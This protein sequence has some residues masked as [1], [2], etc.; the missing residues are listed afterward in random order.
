MEA[1]AQVPIILVINQGLPY[2]SNA[3][4]FVNSRADNSTNV[5]DDKLGLAW[6]IARTQIRLFP[7]APLSSARYWSHSLSWKSSTR[8]QAN[9]RNSPK[10]LKSKRKKESLDCATKSEFA[11]FIHSDYC[12]WVMQSGRKANA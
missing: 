12:D 9:D 8:L 3:P 4:L 10:R 11:R 7:K 5:F 6:L 1:L 2:S